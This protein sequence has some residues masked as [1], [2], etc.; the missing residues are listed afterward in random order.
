LL[1]I[2][3]AL[4]AGGCSSSGGDGSASTLTVPTTEATI[5][6]ASTQPSADP[7]Q[8]SVPDDDVMSDSGDGDSAET[9]TVVV[10][11][12]GTEPFVDLTVASGG[13]AVVTVE[14]SESALYEVDGNESSE[15]SGAVYTLAADTS[16]VDDKP[17]LTIVPEI[18]RLDVSPPAA[19]VLGVWRWQLDR[20]GHVDGV[21]N[22]ERGVRIS[23]QT[24]ALLS[25]PAFVLVTP[26][27]PVG[28]GAVW[29]QTTGP[30]GTTEATVTLL[31]LADDSLRVSIE[32]T[33]TT[34]KGTIAMQTDGVYDRS[35]HVARQVTSEL[36]VTASAEV[37]ENGVT[38]TLVGE[39]RSSR[40]FS[41]VGS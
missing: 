36:V 41:E 37:V 2:A 27:E 39:Q 22:N 13:Q 38:K 18:T 17:V 26:L 12:P 6:T 7:T 35:T 20:R 14:A 40:V 21:A 4:A 16:I 29:Q 15:E 25:V 11:D 32:T 8:S 28:E 19:N 24:A 33:G 1:V 3:V 34:E 10:V 30:D 23:P 9:G 31:E 5:D